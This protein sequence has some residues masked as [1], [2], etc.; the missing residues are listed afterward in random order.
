MIHITKMVIKKHA[1]QGTYELALL[2]GMQHNVHHE[3]ATNASQHFIQL[4]IL[5]YCHTIFYSYLISDKYL[6]IAVGRKCIQATAK[7]WPPVHLIIINYTLITI[8]LT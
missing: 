7:Y 1:S 4:S 2:K 3:L 6:P 8:A 5:F